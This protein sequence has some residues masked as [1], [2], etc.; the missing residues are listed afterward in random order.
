MIQELLAEAESK[1]QHAVEHTQDEF[2]T[3]RTGRANPAILHRVTIDYYG[4]QTSLRELASFSVPEPRLLV[5]Q[6]YDKNSIAAIEKA[7]QTSDL[8]LNPANDG[9]VIRLAFPPL[10]EERRR[11]L[12]RVVRNMAEEGR[13]A[14]RNVRRHTKDDMESLTGDIS[15]DDIRRGEKDLQDVTDRLVAKIDEL[16]AH[17]EEELLEV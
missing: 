4:T 14:I 5:V 13:V 12:I 15:E 8:G 11:E 3:V 16:L 9:N 7:L 17:K 6:P 1:M 2:A 10:N